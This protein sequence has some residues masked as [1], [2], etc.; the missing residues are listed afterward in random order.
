VTQISCDFVPQVA[1]SLTSNGLRP[2]RHREN[3]LTTRGCSTSK[4]L[5][6]RELLTAAFL[7]FVTATPAIAA[8][9]GI[10]SLGGEHNELRP[11]IREDLIVGL[12]DDATGV[13]LNA[14]SLPSRGPASIAR[15][16]EARRDLTE[17]PFEPGLAEA[18]R[19]F[20]ISGVSDDLESFMNHLS[21]PRGSELPNGV[22]FQAIDGPAILVDGLEGNAISYLSPNGEYIVGDRVELDF[23]TGEIHNDPIRWTAE[24]GAEILTIPDRFDRTEFH[25]VTSNGVATALGIVDLDFP[26]P[27]P[28]YAVSG[29]LQWAADGS[30]RVF[31]G[32]DAQER[33]WDVREVFD[34]S[35]DGDLILGRGNQIVFGSS[36][37]EPIVGVFSESGDEWIIGSG[38]PVGDDDV[39]FPS[40]M[41]AD[42]SLVVGR[43]EKRLR[44]GSTAHVWTEAG[45]GQSFATF[46]Q[47]AGIDTSGWT[48]EDV[49][50]VSD[51]GRVFTGYGSFEGS[52][53]YLFYAV[54]PEP[55]TALLLLL[56]L[57]GLAGSRRRLI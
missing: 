15:P 31:E 29:V 38:T 20:R 53:D 51:D 14:N 52:D 3:A 42:G 48:F 16:G 19:S 33:H 47:L 55:S 4:T 39:L 6:R 28:E 26:T 12:R 7:V 30:T 34:V 44:V 10:Y 45:G 17:I 1:T 13:L 32:T 11:D 27:G 35:P 41:T 40:A 22:A 2:S 57:G 37:R 46:L 8:P 54:I 56:G 49:V 23:F 24:G 18:P 25:S 36:V 5:L 9:P 21:F 50:D 43:V